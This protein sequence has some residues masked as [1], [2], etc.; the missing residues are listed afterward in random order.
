MELFK[1]QN[2]I[3][4]AERFNSEEK[5]SGISGTYQMGRRIQVR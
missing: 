5:L 1:G 4:F 2:L 3:E